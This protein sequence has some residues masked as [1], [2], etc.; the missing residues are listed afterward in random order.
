[1]DID[2]FITLRGHVTLSDHIVQTVVD[3]CPLH[4]RKET[5]ALLSR[6]SKLCSCRCYQCGVVNTLQLRGRRSA[7]HFVTHSRPSCSRYLNCSLKDPRSCE[8]QCLL[9]SEWSTKYHVVAKKF[10]MFI[11]RDN[12]C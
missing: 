3:L 9:K 5:G 1:M 8:G 10:Y 11:A 12:V 4:R 7:S 2:T 6:T